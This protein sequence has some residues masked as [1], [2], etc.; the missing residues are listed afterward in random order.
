MNIVICL[1]RQGLFLTNYAIFAQCLLTS[2]F[3]FLIMTS[4]ISKL[5]F[6]LVAIL[7][8]ATT[9]ADDDFEIKDIHLLE[10]EL[11]TEVTIPL[12]VYLILQNDLHA[13]LSYLS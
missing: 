7:A 1:A 5:T 12:Y 8:A 4:N 11:S 9:R 10:K 2:L 13:N 6:T 3:I